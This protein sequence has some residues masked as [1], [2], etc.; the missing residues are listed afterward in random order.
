M[1]VY[2]MLED[3]IK[4]QKAVDILMQQKRELSEQLVEVKRK[5]RKLIQR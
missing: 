4:K 3:Q 2:K 1:K 5:L